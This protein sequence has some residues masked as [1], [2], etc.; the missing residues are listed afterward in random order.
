MVGVGRGCGMRG[1]SV[2]PSVRERCGCPR[3][4]RG[5][6]TMRVPHPCCHTPPPPRRPPEPPA[7]KRHGSLVSERMRRARGERGRGLEGLHDAPARAI[8]PPPPPRPLPCAPRRC[9]RPPVCLPALRYGA[10]A[11]NPRPPRASPPGARLP[12]PARTRGRS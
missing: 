9:L 7:R 1:A 2:P 5:A 8:G 12:S 4:C 6:S 10:G 11:R 3:A